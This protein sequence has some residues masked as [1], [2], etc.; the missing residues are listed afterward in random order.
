MFLVYRASVVLAKWQGK[1]EKMRA[2]TFSN[3]SG[4]DDY[5]KKGYDRLSEQR[6][7]AHL[8]MGCFAQV[9]MGNLHVFVSV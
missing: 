8:G 2:R 5:E 4:H 3:A 9:K 6:L 7:T 1:K